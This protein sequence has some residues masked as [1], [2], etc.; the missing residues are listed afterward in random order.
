MVVVSDLIAPLLR[1]ILPRYF[2]VALRS[3]GLGRAS[4]TTVS[5]GASPVKGIALEPE[6]KWIE[7]MNEVGFMLVTAYFVENGEIYMDYLATRALSIRRTAEYLTQKFL[8][9]NKKWDIPLTT[10]PVKITSV[11]KESRRR[12][13]GVNVHAG[14]GGRRAKTECINS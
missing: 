11:V 10:V 7:T 8:D 4:G 1:H 12:D 3:L 2:Y 13:I 9:I 5:G 6:D 14:V